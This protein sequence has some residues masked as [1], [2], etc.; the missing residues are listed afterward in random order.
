NVA[1]DTK[2]GSSTLS[3]FFAS[4]KNLDESF[5]GLGIYFQ[6]IKTIIRKY[7]EKNLN[8]QKDAWTHF[9]KLMIN[10]KKSI[11]A[12][13]TSLK[14][15]QHHEVPLSNVN[16]WLTICEDS[17]NFVSHLSTQLL[18]HPNSKL[19]CVKLNDYL[20]AARKYP[21]NPQGY[22]SI[23]NRLADIPDAENQLDVIHEAI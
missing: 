16:L 6:D 1:S 13:L 9:L 8:E 18:N 5:P 21:S 10:N 7:P 12:L 4:P 23:L 14:E 15:S 22:I 11:P 20:Y 2:Q 17:A 3:E 19:F